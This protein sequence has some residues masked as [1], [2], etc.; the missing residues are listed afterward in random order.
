[1]SVMRAV[2]CGCEIQKTLSEY[3]SQ[4]GFRLKLHLAVGAGDINMLHLGGVD[5]H[6]EHLIMG[7]P[8]LQVRPQSY[9]SIAPCWCQ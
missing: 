8:L 4:Q 5:G 7:N 1:M 3:D 2:Q 6:Y 9:G